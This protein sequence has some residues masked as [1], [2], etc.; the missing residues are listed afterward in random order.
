MRRAIGSM[1]KEIKS[2]EDSCE[3]EKEQKRAQTAKLD[4]LEGMEATQRKKEIE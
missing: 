4:E 1:E 3:A 2:L